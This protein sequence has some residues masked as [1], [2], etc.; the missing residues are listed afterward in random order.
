MT[1]A[2]WSALATLIALPVG[3][4]IGYRILLW[5]EKRER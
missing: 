5:M 2:D 3:M 4:W 1:P